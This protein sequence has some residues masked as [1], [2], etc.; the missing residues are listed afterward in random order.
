MYKK[1]V[2]F[3]SFLIFLLSLISGQGFGIDYLR[4]RNFTLQRAKLPAYVSN[5]II[6]KFKDNASKKEIESLNLS[7]HASVLYTSSYANFKVIKI[8]PG[9]TVEEMV[10]LYRE[11]PLVE[12]AEPNYIAYACWIPDDPF[13]PYQWHLYQIGMPSAWEIEQGGDS[14]VTVAVI[15]TGI[16]YEDYENF[17]QAPDLEGVNFV[18]GYDFVNDDSHPNDD[19]G[20]GTH[21]TG[22]I[23]QATNNGEGVAGIAFNCS[24]MPVKV[25]NEEGCGD[26]ATVAEGIYYAVDH[27]ADVINLSLGGFESGKT[28]HNAVKY[29]FEH[30][31]VLV[32]A[33]GNFGGPPLLYPAA[34]RECIAVGAV[35]Y[36]KMLS[37]Y[38]TYDEGIELVAPG[39][40]ITVDQNND[41]YPDG[42]LQ[43]TFSGD[44]TNFGYE[45]WQGTSMAAAH[46]TG[47][48]ALVLSQGISGV[49]NVRYILH[50][51]AQDLG[52]S[53]YD[54]F[55][56]YGLVN[57]QGAL[58]T[59]FTVNAYKVY[60]T[61]NPFY[62]KE[63]TYFIFELPEA[64]WVTLKIY[65]ATGDLIRTLVNKKY[66]PDGVSFISWE[67]EDDFGNFVKSGIYIYKISV[68]YTSGGSITKIG[69]VGV[70]R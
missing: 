5:E 64:G 28:L 42:I 24:I 26:Y 23:A 68:E 53:G 2:I 36:D 6:V 40:D 69:T 29:A 58:S 46:V 16:A 15:D 25:L 43:Q 4:K 31:V 20:H 48:V 11:N 62:I 70:I 39:G 7:H 41:G 17:R 59:E 9:K 45:F 38:S 55:Y 49:E 19:N 44:P 10:K 3:F 35:R 51:T 67:G 63:G 52:S 1:L 54:I 8:P 61:R 47:V 37:W 13:F 14:S 18:Q 56:G 34:Y 60:L 12:Y 21:V 32:A 27:G 66:Y 30:N 33:A 57:A 65:D 22:T 50:K